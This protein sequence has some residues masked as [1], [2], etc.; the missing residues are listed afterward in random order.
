MAFPSTLRLFE[1][2][3]FAAWRVAFVLFALF[4]GW[5]W[6]LWMLAGELLTGIALRRAHEHNRRLEH[7]IDLAL[8]DALAWKRR[9]ERAERDR[10]EGEVNA[11]RLAYAN[12]W[13]KA[14][15]I[16]REYAHLG[17]AGYN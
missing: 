14:G 1:W 9:A 15:R 13:N 11:A 5:T 3:M 2:T 4:F 17:M 6:L 10:L 16:R 7:G 8:R 12:R